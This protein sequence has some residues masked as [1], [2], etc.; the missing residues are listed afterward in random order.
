MLLWKFG[1]NVEFSLLMK[2]AGCIPA[3]LLLYIALMNHR[4][5]IKVLVVYE[6]EKGYG[7]SKGLYDRYA[8]IARY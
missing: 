5:T 2:L 4:D 8:C 3:F 6:E 7:K 1:W